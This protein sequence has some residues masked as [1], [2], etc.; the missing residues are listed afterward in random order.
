MSDGHGHDCAHPASSGAGEGY[1]PGADG[2]S[3]V[4]DIKTL[5]ASG[6]PVAESKNEFVMTTRSVREKPFG[7]SLAGD[8]G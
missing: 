4:P 1:G 6:A 8:E 5:E 3:P 2:R 7:F